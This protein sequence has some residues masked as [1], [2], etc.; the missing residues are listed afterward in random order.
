MA[1]DAVATCRAAADDPI[2]LEGVRSI[3][4]SLDRPVRPL[5]L[6]ALLQ[7]PRLAD[8][9]GLISIAMA[10]PELTELAEEL[11]VATEWLVPD[12]NV[13]LHSLCFSP[14]EPNRADSVMK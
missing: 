5:H 9:Q 13:S 3:A 10:Y 1:I 6:Q 12:A 2:L 7:L 4:H 11:P 14:V 8:E